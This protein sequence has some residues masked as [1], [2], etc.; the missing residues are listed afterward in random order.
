MSKVTDLQFLII[1]RPIRELVDSLCKNGVD[2]QYLGKSY[3]TWPST[4]TVFMHSCPKA[5]LKPVKHRSMQKAKFY[6][7]FQ[8]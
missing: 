8:V 4:Q 6:S 2:T 7:I 5:P 1:R 3:I